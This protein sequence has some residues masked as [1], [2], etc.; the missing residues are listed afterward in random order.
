MERGRE[1]GREIS[2]EIHFRYNSQEKLRD[3]QNDHVDGKKSVEGK[4]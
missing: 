4:S 2:I 1:E 3:V